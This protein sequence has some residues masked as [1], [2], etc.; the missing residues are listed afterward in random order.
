MNRSYL[1]QNG[2]FLLLQGFPT[3]IIEKPQVAYFICK[4]Q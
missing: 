1:R 2:V 4:L 3:T